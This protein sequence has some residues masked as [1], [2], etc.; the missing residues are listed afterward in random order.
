M[1]EYRDEFKSAQAEA[2]WSLPRMLFVGLL[3]MMGLYGL[4]FIATG[5]DL[6]IYKFW[7]PKQENAKRVVFENT[8][9]YVQGKQEYIGRLRYQ[10]QSAESGAQREALRSLIL[11][12]AST[13]DTSKLSVDVQAFLRS[14]GGA[15]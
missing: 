9:S 6:V 1:S 3:L 10:Y 2:V 14:I 15:Q 11:S 7:A 4:G 13:V 5:G 8:Q 12:E